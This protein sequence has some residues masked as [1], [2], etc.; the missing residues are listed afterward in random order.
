[1]SQQDQH[2]MH[3]AL[4]LADKAEQLGEVPIGAVVVYQDEVIGEG[5]NQSITSLDPSAHAEMVAIRAA[6]KHIGNYR[7]VDCTLYV[8][9]EPCTMCMGLLIHSRISRLVYGAVEPKAGAISSTLNIHSLTHFNHRFDITSGVLA[10]QCSTK[11]SNF[12]KERRARKKQL[13]DSV[14]V[15]KES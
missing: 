15:H 1:M 14:Q 8:T 2:Y 6:A 10:E 11:M 13:K 9:L 3:R 5:F 7:L 4:G 12:F